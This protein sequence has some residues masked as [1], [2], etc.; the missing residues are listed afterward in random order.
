MIEL[1]ARLAALHD[2]QQGTADP[3]P[4][5]DADIAFIEPVGDQV[6]AEA[7]WAEEMGD[8]G[9]LRPPCLVMVERILQQRLIGAAMDDGFGLLIALDAELA[10]LDRA[11]APLLVDSGRDAGAG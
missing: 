4:I 11:G 3:H 2:L 10:D 5:A 9:D 1:V 8:V 6:F 7:A